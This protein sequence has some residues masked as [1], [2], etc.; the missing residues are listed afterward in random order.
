MP[1]L[2]HLSEVSVPCQQPFV[3]L[4][5]L[6]LDSWHYEIV[7]ARGLGLGEFGRQAGHLLAAAN[8]FEPCKDID[9]LQTED[10]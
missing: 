1:L 9:G 6:N 10:T 5:T 4:A 8:Q 7:L 3:P 2:G